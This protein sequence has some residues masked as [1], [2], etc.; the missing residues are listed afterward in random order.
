MK[1]RRRKNTHTPHKY[2]YLTD[3]RKKSNERSVR[4]HL[5]YS[6]YVIPILLSLIKKSKFYFQRMSLF[7]RQRII[8]L[9]TYLQAKRKRCSCQWNRK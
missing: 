3:R 7:M 1:R 8:T 2:T 6:K 9:F 5:F 4:V